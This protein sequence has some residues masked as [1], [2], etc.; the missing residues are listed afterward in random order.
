MRSITES[1]RC[2]V[3]PG[4]SGIWEVR[5][6]TIDEASAA[7]STV[8]DGHR[9]L[10]VGEYTG[11]FRRGQVIMSD[12]P[13]EVRDH[14]EPVLRARDVCLISGLGLGCVAQGMLQK[15]DVDKVV[16][17][18]RSL[19]VIN[20]VA[21]FYQERY[22]DRFECILADAYEY[23]PPKG[24]RYGAVWHDIWDD[25]CADNLPEMTKLHRKYGRRADWQGSWGKELIRSFERRRKAGGGY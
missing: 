6:F 24:Q 4:S 22:G 17:I 20:L 8:I 16:V 25:L 14:L 12:T 2:E 19:D 18:E 9:C 13:A 15:Q 21:P 7:L 23:K 11:L 3:Q 10:R 1:M 5:R